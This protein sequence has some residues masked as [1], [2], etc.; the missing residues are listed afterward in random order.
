MGRGRGA[1]YLDTTTPRQS[2]GVHRQLSLG[3]VHRRVSALSA[4]ADYSLL[5]GFMSVR[6]VKNPGTYLTRISTLDSIRSTLDDLESQLPYPLK[7]VGSV[8]AHVV[9]ATGVRKCD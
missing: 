6:S 2:R 7:R 9:H 3:T 1:G 4:I 8:N 5:K